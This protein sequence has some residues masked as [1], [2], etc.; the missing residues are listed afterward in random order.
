MYMFKDTGTGTAPITGNVSTV[1]T[2]S[3]AGT[4][5]TLIESALA[6]V[7]SDCIQDASACPSGVTP[8]TAAAQLS[9]AG[10]W[11][12]RLSAGEKVVSGA[13]TL[14]GTT[15]FNTNLPTTVS[16]AQCSNLGEA[17]QYQVDFR[18]ASSVNN[19]DTSNAALTA[20]DRYS[21]NQAGGFLPTGVPVVIKVGDEYKQVICSG[22][23]CEDAKGFA[24]QTRMRTYWYKETD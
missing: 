22:V 17:R 13:V 6:D 3:P 8:T 7:T 9:A 14:G 15:Y 5:A 4:S 18:N 19:L 23:Q 2:L 24:M 12:V 11:Y 20:G 16:S 21:V 10:G 1:P